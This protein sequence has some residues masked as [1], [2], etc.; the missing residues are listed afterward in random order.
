MLYIT[1]IPLIKTRFQRITN[2]FANKRK[3]E[4]KKQKTESSQT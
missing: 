4:E 3:H 1:N 2:K